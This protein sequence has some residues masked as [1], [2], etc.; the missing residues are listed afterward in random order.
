MEALMCVTV[1]SD[2][3]PEVLRGIAEAIE[4]K[5]VRAVSLPE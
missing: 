5:R 2:V 1:D 3:P 4:A